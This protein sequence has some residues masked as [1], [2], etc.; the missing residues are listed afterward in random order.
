V[1][2]RPTDTIGVFTHLLYLLLGGLLV[3]GFATAIVDGIATQ[4]ESPCRVLNPT[5]RDGPAPSFTVQDLAGNEVSLEDFRGKFVVL[6]FWATWCEPCITE[7]PQVHQLA[8]RLADREDIVVIAMSIDENRDA[9]APFLERMVL[10]DTPVTVL[11]DPEQN[12]QTQFGTSKIPDTYFIDE[13]GDLVHEYVNI[14]KWGSP[15]AQQCVLSRVG[16]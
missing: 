3:F 15:E 6:N 11:W 16:R 1:A 4:V 5:E 14:R 12:V 10:S 7:W 9:I 8:E 2:A 13:R